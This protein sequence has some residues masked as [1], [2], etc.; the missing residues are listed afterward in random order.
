MLI[1]QNQVDDERA[2]MDGWACMSRGVHSVPRDVFD[3]LPGGDVGVVLPAPNEGG[4]AFWSRT[5]E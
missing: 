5:G 1:A 2:V 3:A 4:S